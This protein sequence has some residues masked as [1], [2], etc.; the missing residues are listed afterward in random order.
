MLTAIIVAAGSSRRMGFDKLFAPLLDKPVI[1]HT[2]D[3]FERANCVSEIVIVARQDRHDEIAKIASAKTKAIIAGGEH[4]QDSVAAGLLHLGANARYVAVHDA[5]R[6]LVTPEMIERV[7]AKA[8]ETV[9]LLRRKPLA[10][11][12]N[13]PMSI[14]PSRNQ[15][16]DINSSPCKRRKYS[17]A[18]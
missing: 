12:S 18:H 10:T 8:Q 1:A 13:A 7:F 2:L 17:S 14:L 15:W 4:R 16:I 5:A 6:P 9:R 3:A 11:H